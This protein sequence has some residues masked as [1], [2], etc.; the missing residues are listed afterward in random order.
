MKIARTRKNLYCIGSDIFS[1]RKK[2]QALE[3]IKATFPL[4]YPVHEGMSAKPLSKLL[5]F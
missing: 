4:K 3:S 1:R 2:D 5:N